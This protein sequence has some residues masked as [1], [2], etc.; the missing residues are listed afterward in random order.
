VRVPRFSARPGKSS[1]AQSSQHL[2]RLL[3]R[4]RPACSPTDGGEDKLPFHTVF[5]DLEVRILADQERR[6]TSRW[7]AGHLDLGQIDD[8]GGR[9]EEHALAGA[10][11]TRDPSRPGPSSTTSIGASVRIFGPGVEDWARIR[12]VRR[13]AGVAMSAWV[14]R[15]GGRAPPVLGSGLAPSC[16]GDPPASSSTRR[17]A[18]ACS[19]ESCVTQRIPRPADTSGPSAAR[20]ARRLSGPGGLPPHPPAGNRAGTRG[21]PQQHELLPPGRKGLGSDGQI[22]L[23]SER[24]APATDSRLDGF[25]AHSEVA[26]GQAEL[27][28]HRRRE[29]LDRG[30]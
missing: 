29:Q 17:F 6:M 27:L 5:E 24:R 21:L 30:S 10:I 12:M 28:A 22:C 23:E 4:G 9:G 11:G 13:E 15:K 14:W 20:T 18:A 3:E 26:G 1:E 25:P 8:T 2:A 7:L 19:S 16:P